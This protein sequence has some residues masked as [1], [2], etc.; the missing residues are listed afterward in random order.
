MKYRV[1]QIEQSI[2]RRNE[3]LAAALRA[4]WAAS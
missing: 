2:M 3:G 1:V 4:T